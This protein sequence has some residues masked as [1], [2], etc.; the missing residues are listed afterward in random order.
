MVEKYPHT[1]TIYWYDPGTFNT[2][3]VRA[4]GTL[5]TINIVCDI[6]DVGD[7]I[8][9]GAGGKVLN[10]NWKIFSEPNSQFSGVP[11]DAKL[12]FFSADHILVKLLE[13][14]KHAEIKCQA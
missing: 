10:Y 7:Q 13:Y 2:V 3:G 1:A 4:E 12:T 6:Q 11:E 8:A 14:Q 5:N 9:A